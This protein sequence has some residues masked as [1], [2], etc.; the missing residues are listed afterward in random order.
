MYKIPLSYIHQRGFT[1]I[2]LMTALLIGLIV[3]AGSAMAYSTVQQTL[4]KKLS[5]DAEQDALRFLTTRVASLVRSSHKIQLAKNNGVHVLT[6]ST[7]V[8]DALCPANNDALTLTFEEGIMT[9]QN[10]GHIIMQNLPSIEGMDL[11]EVNGKAYG[12][13]LRFKSQ[14]THRSFPVLLATRQPLVE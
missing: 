5:I 11:I 2:E 6:L 7:Q 8:D 13:N 9:C 3:I 12:V 14:L 1:I 10:G 4:I